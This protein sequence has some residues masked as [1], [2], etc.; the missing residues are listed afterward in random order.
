MNSSS[1]MHRRGFYSSR[2]KLGEEDSRPDQA[3]Q[4]RCQTPTETA[5]PR[6]SD[7]REKSFW[8]K[9][10]RFPMEIQISDGKWLHR[11]FQRN[12]ILIRWNFRRNSQAL[13]PKKFRSGFLCLECAC[14]ALISAVK[15]ENES[16]E[17]GAR[18]REKAEDSWFLVADDREKE[19]PSC[20]IQW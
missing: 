17:E 18:K 8:R 10:H 14:V 19:L 11:K 1:N 5:M 20:I 16:Y 2:S 3:L 12:S 7:G 9:H 13:F 4:K 6:A 15:T